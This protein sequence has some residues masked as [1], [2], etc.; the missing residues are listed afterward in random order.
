MNKALSGSAPI[1]Q[2]IEEAYLAALSRPPSRPEKERLV[3]LFA[4]AREEK[5]KRALLEDTY[6]ALLSTNEFLFNH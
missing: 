1:E 6:W 3:E 5:E 2:V 4:G